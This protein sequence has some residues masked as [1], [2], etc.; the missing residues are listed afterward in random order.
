MSGVVPSKGSD[1]FYDGYSLADLFGSES[2]L[3]ERLSE[4]LIYSV[5]LRVNPMAIT[6]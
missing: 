3:L 2:G 4:L 6:G 1:E 5:N